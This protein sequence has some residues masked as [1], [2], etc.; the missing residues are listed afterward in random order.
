MT[1]RPQGFQYV[2]SG[3]TQAAL[4]GKTLRCVRTLGHCI[5]AAV[6][7]VA[8]SAYGMQVNSSLSVKEPAAKSAA[9]KAAP[10]KKAA[11][12][13]TDGVQKNAPR[14]PAKSTK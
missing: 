12:A 2:L 7:M 11:D 10:K 8:V 1:E 13:S 9:D 14:I 4:P 5:V 6:A 3:T